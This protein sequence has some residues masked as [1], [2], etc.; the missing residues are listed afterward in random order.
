MHKVKKKISSIYS[1]L[2]TMRITGCINFCFYYLHI[3]VYF[4]LALVK[5]LIELKKKNV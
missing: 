5:S 2:E 4:T 1:F 3:F